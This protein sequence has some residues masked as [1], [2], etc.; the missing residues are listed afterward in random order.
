VANDC[1]VVMAL[2]GVVLD[3]QGAPITPMHDSLR[4]GRISLARKKDGPTPVVLGVQLASRMSLL[5]GDTVTVI[6]YENLKWSPNGDP[7]FRPE[8]WIVSGVFSTGMYDFDLRQGYAALEDVQRLLELDKDVA[9]IVG[10]RAD[11]PWRADALADSVRDALGGWP[12]VVTSWTEDNRQL[13]SALKLEK[14]AMALILSLIVIVAALNIVGT[15]VMVVVN[16][17]REI[18]I[19][20]AMG[21]TRR[22][23]LRAFMFQGMWIG[24]AGTL[25]GTALGLGLAVLI[26]HYGLIR[27]PPE[28]YF[29]DRLPV[30]LTPWDITWIAGGSLLISILATI[31][32]ARQASALEPVE[33]FRHD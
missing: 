26:G 18:G 9:S 11:D 23:T 31:Y 10:A 14:L 20:K 16:R 3:D 5:V 2:Y 12:Y 32:P 28:V 29:V 6:A 15:L 33:A 7:V 24:V 30:E 19:L 8:D 17:T 22:D 25:V 1:V 27:L 21:L 4:T 13:F